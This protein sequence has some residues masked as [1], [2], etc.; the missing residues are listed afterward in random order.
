MFLGSNEFFLN[1][2]Q[3]FYIKRNGFL[4]VVG[5]PVFVKTLRKATENNCCG[6]MKW[7]TKWC[8]VTVKFNSKKLCNS[9]LNCN[10]GI[11]YGFFTG[12]DEAKTVVS[13]TLEHK[14]GWSFITEI[15]QGLEGMGSIGLVKKGLRDPQKISITTP[16]MIF[17]FMWD[18]DFLEILGKTP[19][20]NLFKNIFKKSWFQ[21]IICFPWDTIG[22]KF[23][24]YKSEYVFISVIVCNRFV[25][26]LREAQER[27]H[28]SPHKMRHRIMLWNSATHRDDDTVLIT[29]I[30]IKTVKSHQSQW[31]FDYGREL[32]HSWNKTFRSHKVCSINPAKSF[33]HVSKSFEWF[34][35]TYLPDEHANFC[36]LWPPEGIIFINLEAFKELFSTI[37]TPSGNFLPSILTSK[38]TFYCLFWTPK[39]ISS[40]I[41]W[42]SEDNVFVYFHLPD[43]SC[44]YFVP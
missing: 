43:M 4:S 28:C 20:K 38:G 5:Y 27:T 2:S 44:V 19:S 13:S 26:A 24:F 40:K 42:S 33:V 11:G 8:C 29:A 35:S 39:D 17:C 7:N 31:L 34:S 12:I 16:H 6:H 15:L 14:V 22:S 30:F 9:A 23:E 36:R 1:I 41:F 32:F 21:K 10:E 37:F 18:I 25:E 3:N